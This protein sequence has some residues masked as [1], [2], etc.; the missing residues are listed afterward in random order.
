MLKKLIREWDRKLK[1]SGFIDIE[2]RETGL[3]KNWSGQVSYGSTYRDDDTFID[4]VN[5]H[6]RHYGYGSLAYQE[7]KAEYFRLAAQCLHDKEFKSVVHKEIWELHCEGLSFDKIGRKLN[8]T[9]PQVRY[10]IENM[11]KEFS[12][13]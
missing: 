13:K 9:T 11:A 5:K 12:L 6:N 8:L 10:A 1:D 7:S 2:D 3:I 4:K